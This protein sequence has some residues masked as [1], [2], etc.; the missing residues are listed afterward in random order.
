MPNLVWL[1]DQLSKLS[2]RSD[3]FTGVTPEGR[4]ELVL[5]ENWLQEFKARAGS[6]RK[7]CADRSKAGCTNE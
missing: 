2:D 1:P 3:S 7:S 4:T 6:S 5:T